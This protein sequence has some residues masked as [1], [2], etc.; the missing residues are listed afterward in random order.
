MRFEEY[1]VNGVVVGGR[2]WVL[3]PFDN[4]KELAVLLLLVD[5]VGPGRRLQG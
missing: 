2:E 5:I 3:V 4:M 1:V